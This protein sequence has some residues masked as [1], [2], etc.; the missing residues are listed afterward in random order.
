[1]N[2]SLSGSAVHE[3]LQ[4]RILQWVAIP[5]SRGFRDWTQIS[6]IAGRLFTIWFT[7]NRWGESWSSN[8]LLIECGGFSLAGYC[9]VR[10]KPSLCWSSTVS[11]FL[12]EMHGASLFLFWG[13]A[14]QGMIRHESSPVGASG[15]P[16]F[17]FIFLSCFFCYVFGVLDGMRDHSSQPGWTPSPLQWKFGVLTTGL[18]EESLFFF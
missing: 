10:R 14:A 5:F 2:C 6:C 17:Y 1:M 7:R 9:W 12:L 15:H 18:P 8:F 13:S 4:A 3:I 11:L 16:S